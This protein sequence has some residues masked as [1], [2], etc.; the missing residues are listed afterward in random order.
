VLCAVIGITVLPHF[1]NFWQKSAFTTDIDADAGPGLGSRFNI[2]FLFFVAV[3]FAISVSILLSYHLHLVSR[4]RT[5]LES[6][7]PPIFYPSGEDKTAFD[8]G[9]LNNVEQV[10][11]KRKI[12]WLVPIRTCLGDGVSFPLRPGTRAATTYQ[13]MEE[14]NPLYGSG[15][16][17]HANGSVSDYPFRGVV[18]DSG[19]K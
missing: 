9:W 3:M 12:L 19:S 7:R 16:P 17:H 6:F 14:G 10:F 8:L 15:E 4:N 13:T 2:L 1:I 11:G 5:T 18:V